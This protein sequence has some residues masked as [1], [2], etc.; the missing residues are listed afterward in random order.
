MWVP[1]A[2]V[3]IIAWAVVT[4]AKIS[5][6]NSKSASREI[7]SEMMERLKEAEAERGELI[8]RVQQLEA[9][10]TDDSDRPLL[11]PPMD[12][13]WMDNTES[14]DLSGERARI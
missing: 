8:R 6:R 10:V 4:I 14:H 13:D 12:D 2:I 3:A 1:V 5:S 7:L 11:A 9:I